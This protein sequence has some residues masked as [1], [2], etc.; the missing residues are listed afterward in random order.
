LK[1]QTCEVKRKKNNKGKLTTTIIF[2]QNET[3]KKLGTIIFTNLLKI[4]K[5]KLYAPSSI[6]TKSVKVPPIKYKPAR[7][8]GDNLISAMYIISC[9][10]TFKINKH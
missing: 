6:G 4:L 5:I 2:L 1:S 8:K 9:K 3:K 7:P 10:H